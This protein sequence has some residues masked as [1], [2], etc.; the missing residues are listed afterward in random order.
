MIVLARP[1]L[2]GSALSLVPD[3]W[4]LRWPPLPFPDGDYMAFRAETMFGPGE[5]GL[6]DQELIDYLEWCHRLGSPSR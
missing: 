2:W 4:W 1:H 5:Q 3:R 6:S